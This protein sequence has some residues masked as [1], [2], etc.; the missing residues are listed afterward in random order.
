M[1]AFVSLLGNGSDD[2]D[3]DEL[4]MQKRE[5][6]M[7]L[8]FGKRELDRYEQEYEEY[9]KQA[10]F[11]DDPDQ[12]YKKS[13]LRLS[14]FR[15]KRAEYE[16]HAKVYLMFLILT[17]VDD[18][19]S[20]LQETELDESD[21]LS[22]RQRDIARTVCRNRKIEEI[23][24]TLDCRLDDSELP[25]EYREVV[26][27]TESRFSIS[28]DAGDYPEHE[29]KITWLEQITETVLDDN[30]GAIESSSL[31]DDFPVLSDIVSSEDRSDDGY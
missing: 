11:A 24:T 16:K 6:A 14:K 3:R 5:C 20:D 22:N 12:Y 29:L 7:E 1:L 17:I 23:R 31:P 25:S 2:I 15:S 27:E 28:A 10:N 19:H 18:H 4:E 30:I 8:D 13:A 21:E 9:V 26:E